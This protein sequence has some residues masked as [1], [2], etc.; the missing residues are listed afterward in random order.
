MF[1]THNSGHPVV[2]QGDSTFKIAKEDLCLTTANTNE[3]GNK[4]H[5]VALAITTTECSMAYGALYSYLVRILHVVKDLDCWQ[6]ECQLCEEMR[7]IRSRPQFK[8]WSSGIVLDAL[9]SFPISF[10]MSD[11][12]GKFFKF[13][14][15]LIPGALRNGC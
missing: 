6:S 15:E 2:Y 12:T 14:K 11:N 7:G 13:A 10:T 1:R 9:L 3:L 8:D 4:N 5:I